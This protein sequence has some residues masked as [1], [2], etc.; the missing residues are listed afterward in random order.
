MIIMYVVICKLYFFFNGGFN[1]KKIREIILLFLERTSNR[2]IY[3]IFYII[4][5]RLRCMGILIVL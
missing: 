1:K 4:W 5:I 2:S 3:E